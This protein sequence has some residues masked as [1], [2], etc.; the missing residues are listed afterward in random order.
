MCALRTTRRKFVGA[1][2]YRKICK[3][4]HLD[5]SEN[6][7]TPKS[8]TLIGFSIIN[9]PFWGTPIFGNIHLGGLTARHMTHPGP[10]KNQGFYTARPKGLKQGH[11]SC[12]T[13]VSNLHVGILRVVKEFEIPRDYYTELL[14]AYQSCSICNISQT[15]EIG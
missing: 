6:S 14:M 8:S 4:S 7:G 3:G 11:D 2:R 9:H 13:C 1:A 10:E 12:R 15:L 5:V